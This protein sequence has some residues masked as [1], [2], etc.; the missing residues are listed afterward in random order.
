MRDMCEAF[1][2]KGESVALGGCN[3]CHV[4]CQLRAIIPARNVRLDV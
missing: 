3:G 1:L 4:L 2:A